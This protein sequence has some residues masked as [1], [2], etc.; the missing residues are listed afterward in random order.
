MSDTRIDVASEPRRGTVRQREDP[1]HVVGLIDASQFVGVA[2]QLALLLA[3][4][5]LYRIEIQRGFAIVA[6]LIFVGFMIHTWLPFRWRLPF[7]LGLTVTAIGFLLRE[8]GFWFLAIGLGLLGLCHLPI[9]WSIRLG[10]VLFATAGLAVLQA[11]FVHTPWAQTVIPVLAAI[12]MFRLALYLYDLKTDRTPAN[13]WQRLAYFFMLPN[14]CFPLFP[15]VDYKTFLRT[16]YDAPAADIY[17]KG[18]YWML[19][20]VTHLLLYRLLYYALPRIESD[21]SGIFGVY[22]FMAM[23]YGLYLRVSGLFHLITGSLCLFGFNLP[24]TNHHYFLASSF[25]DLWRRINIYW[26]DFMMTIIF[27]PVFMKARRWSMVQRLLFATACVFLVTWFL[28]SYQWFWLRGVLPIRGV[29]IAFW[30]ILGGALAIN[31]VWEARHGRRVRPGSRGW[32]WKGAFGVTARTIGVFSMMAVLWSLWDSGSFSEWG[33]R[34]LRVGESNTVDWVLFISLIV[35]A[36]IVGIGAHWL[37][38]RGWGLDGL[39]QITWRHASRLVPA[40]TMVML[41]VGFPFVHREAGWPIERVVSAVQSTGPNR[42]DRGRQER[43]YY[44]TLSRATELGSIPDVRSPDD[45]PD[46][47]VGFRDSPAARLTGDLRGYEIVPGVEVE[48]KGSTFRSNRWGMRDRDY[49]KTKPPGTYR[50]ALLGFSHEMGSGVENEETF[51]N[52]LEDRL[53]R[54]LVGNGFERYEVL[55]FAVGGHGLPQALY[56]AEHRVP[57]FQVDAVMYTVHS[58]EI[59]R[60]IDRIRKV[61]LLGAEWGAEYEYITR[62]LEHSNAHPRMPSEEFARRVQPYSDEL[63]RWAYGRMA[64]SIRRQGAVP[65][66][67]FLSETDEDFRPA[68]LA[69]LESLARESGAMVLDLS[70]VYRGYDRKRLWVAEWDPHPN[71]FGHQVIADRLYEALVTNAKTLGMIHQDPVASVDVTAATG[72]VASSP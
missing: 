32:S 19:R 12:F 42:I 2:L 54:E 4:T 11:G 64:S 47:W 63:M 41:V 16:Y 34:V 46:D 29:D 48:F 45:R 51:E 53:N 9:S 28:H 44:E 7:F 38:S 1:G 5:M 68:E 20:G 65:L 33:Y 71:A 8:N 31:S 23:T 37:G 69:K 6:V 25:T 49:E 39:E 58:G 30:G 66:F 35:G 52:V 67:V 70:E 18:V 3:V 40:S 55:N 22:I 14:I 17:Q 50:L 43:A 60:T 21:L 59:Y 36:L 72:A 61:L 24:R 13:T 57:D 15:V 27:Y 56:I 10:L 26:K 62:V